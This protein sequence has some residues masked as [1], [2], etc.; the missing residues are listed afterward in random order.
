[1]LI[2]T[3][4]LI[5]PFNIGIAANNVYALALG[6]LTYFRLSIDLPETILPSGFWIKNSIPSVNTPS[7]SCLFPYTIYPVLR[8]LTVVVIF[9]I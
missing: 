2:W 4:I 8:E 3:G 9:D 7:A 6:S 5:L 1:M